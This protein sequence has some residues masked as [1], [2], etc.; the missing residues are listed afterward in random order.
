V[1]VLAPQRSWFRRHGVLGLRFADGLSGEVEVLDGCVDLSSTRSMTL[2]DRDNARLVGIGFYT[3]AG[4]AQE[5]DALA[6][7]LFDEARDRIPQ[8]R[9]KDPRLQVL[10]LGSRQ[11]CSP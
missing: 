2:V 4:A 7:G 6:E 8:S 10:V 9:S 3:S 11:A 1:H 5:A